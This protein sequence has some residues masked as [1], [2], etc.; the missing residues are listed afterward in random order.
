MLE[1]LAIIVL[2]A[3]V[4]I[5]VISPEVIITLIVDILMPRFDEDKRKK[6]R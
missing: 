1:I 2:L 4:L 6:R 3:G 5:I